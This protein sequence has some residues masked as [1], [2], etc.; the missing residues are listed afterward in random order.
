[1]RATASRHALLDLT[2]WHW[3]CAAEGG[4]GLS[5]LC[6]LFIRLNIGGSYCLRQIERLSTEG[7]LHL[8]VRHPGSAQ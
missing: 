6:G 3:T 1:V 5:L 8:K 2:E 4:S 7:R